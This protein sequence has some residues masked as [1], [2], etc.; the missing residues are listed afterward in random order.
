MIQRP[1]RTSQDH[2]MWIS[3]LG[4]SLAINIQWSSGSMAGAMT[5]LISHSLTSVNNIRSSV[6][7]LWEWMMKM[8]SQVKAEFL[9]TWAMPTA[10]AHAQVS[11]NR[12][13][14]KVAKS[15]RRALDAIALHALMMSISLRRSSPKSKKTFASTRADSTLQEQAMEVCSLTIL[16]RR[17]QNWSTVGCSCLGSLW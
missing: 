17:F 11:L 13:V 12:L 14:T 7:I 15:W 6:F 16:F 4:T 3:Q 10:L 8:L 5:P 1:T 2:I 9:G